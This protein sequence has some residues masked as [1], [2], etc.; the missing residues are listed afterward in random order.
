MVVFTLDGKMVHGYQLP[1][2]QRMILRVPS[3]VYIVKA[4]TQ[5]CVQAKGLKVAVR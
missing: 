3:G 1:D 4:S 2:K 5:S